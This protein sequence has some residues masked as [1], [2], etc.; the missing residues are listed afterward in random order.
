LLELDAGP[1]YRLDANGNVLGGIRTPSVDAPIATLSG[2]G[3]TG[4]SFCFLFGTT[5][6][7]SDARLSALYPTEHAYVSAVARSARAALRDGF[8]LRPEARAI[9]RAAAAS[10]VGG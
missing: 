8:L 4:S 1:A 5:V 10:G 2:L 3:Q 9:R 6:P 7:L